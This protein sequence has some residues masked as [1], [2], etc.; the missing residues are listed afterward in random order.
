MFLLQMSHQFCRRFS[1]KNT[2]FTKW[3][4]FY[5]SKLYLDAFC[6][7]L[8]L[9]SN[10]LAGN[11]LSPDMIDLARAS[12]FGDWRSMSLG[13]LMPVGVVH[14]GVVPGGPGGPPPLLTSSLFLGIS[15]L[16]IMTAPSSYTQACIFLYESLPFSVSFSHDLG[17]ERSSL[18]VP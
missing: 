17:L 6:K 14:G 9:K 4:F 5:L 8:T 13:P 2:H 11:L 3:F 18:T 15:D 12:K 1:V 7:T 10:G 16:S